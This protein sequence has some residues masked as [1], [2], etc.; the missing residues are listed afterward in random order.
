MVK[1]VQ[2]IESGRE[3]MIDSALQIRINKQA[4][5]RNKAME[6]GTL[7]LRL[8]FVFWGQFRRV[9]SELE[10]LD[11]WDTNNVQTKKKAMTT[12]EMLERAQRFSQQN[13]SKEQRSKETYKQKPTEL[14]LEPVQE[15][16]DDDN[17]ISTSPKKRPT[18][19]KSASSYRRTQNHGDKD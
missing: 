14:T 4:R 2:L 5:A 9:L 1:P 16:K 13:S 17:P 15:Q 19:P 3:D 7:I 6:T 18:S 10:L 8:V 11:L 12:T